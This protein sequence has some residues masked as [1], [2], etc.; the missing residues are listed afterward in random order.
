MLADGAGKNRL[1]RDAS[2]ARR[3]SWRAFILS[4]GEPD[5]ATVVAR[6]GQRL[7]AGAEVRLASVPVDDAATTWPSLHGRSDFTT[8]S[9]DLHAAFRRQHGTAARGFVTRLATERASDPAALA[10]FIEALRT[11]IADRLP[12]NAD[13]QVC[14]VAR[15][16]ALVAA[17]GEL[18]AAWNVLPWQPGEAERAAVA[19]L[20]AWLARRPGGVGAAEAAAQLDR[21]R[22]AL[23][24]HGAARF[25]VLEKDHD[26]SW[27]EADPNRPVVNRIGWRKRDAGRDEFLIPPEM[28]RAELCVP[29]ALDPIA[30]ART[31]V[32]G[33]FLRRDRKNLTVNE[34]IPGIGRMR[35]YAVKAALLK[36]ADADTGTA[37][38]GPRA[39]A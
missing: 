9:C 38:D 6:S 25:T 27:S 5:I 28:W 22:A 30:T 17:A 7:P 3:R 29:A 12:A 14:D 33:G 37:E 36:S 18:A 11:R 4:T 23:V 26:G 20:S 1:R 39:A 31:L 13:A 19:M 24:Q 32:E 10:S 16:F 34:R 2:A 35:V 8:F 21:V 15:R